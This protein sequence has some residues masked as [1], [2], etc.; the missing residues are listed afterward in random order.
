MMDKTKIIPIILL[1]VILGVGYVA[2]TFYTQTENLTVANQTL[3]EE[4]GSLLEAN[5]NLQYK[6]D[7][8][9]REK[10]DID[11]RLTMVTNELSK[12]EDGIK[13]WE[14]KWSLVSKER[15]TLVE[16]MKTA[17]SSSIRVTEKV[18][19]SGIN[20]SSSEDHWADF[21]KS[22]ASAEA[23]LD[24]L[25]KTLFEEKN[26]MVKL[27]KENKELSI[28]MDQLTKEKDRLVE[29]I[30]FKERTLR[31]MSMDL[32]SEREGRGT[33]I[34]EVRKLRKENLGLKREVIMANKGL[35][36]LQYTLQEVI[37]KKEDLEDKISDVDVILKE[38]AMAF[39]ELQGQLEV[40]I[41]GGKK[42]TAEE[43]ASVELPPIIV[44][45]NAQ[46]ILELRGEIIAVNHEEKFVVIDMG[47]ASG[48]R[49]G[50][51]LRIMRG[52]K[53]VGSVEVIEM[54]KEISAADI[55]EIVDGYVIQEG[56]I[57]MA[58]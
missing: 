27:G 26:K 7:K 13:N 8:I 56:D 41:E 42:I 22:K 45:P 50:A 34:L 4:R 16:K 43:S 20:F 47:E 52:D 55:K 31:I 28:Q 10:S 57:A 36:K 40:T 44:K 58:Q 23:K 18:E 21:V 38:K 53:K 24:I 2:F 33:V 15:D 51:L 54:R 11:R 32:V 25:S 37:L 30:K 14:R 48:L 5:N 49:P 46:G 35:M 19:E 3:T 17:A 29:D 1:V 12:A 6:V 9:G 39:E